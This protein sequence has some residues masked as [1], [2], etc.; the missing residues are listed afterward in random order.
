VWTKNFKTPPSVE[1]D[2]EMER[3]GSGK[4]SCDEDAFEKQMCLVNTS[5]EAQVRPSPSEGY[6]KAQVDHLED[7]LKEKPIPLHLE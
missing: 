3:E 1:D 4:P 2:V 7:W 6:V 5:Y